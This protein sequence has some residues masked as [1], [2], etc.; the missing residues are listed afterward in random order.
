[1]NMNMFVSVFAF[2][3][4]FFQIVQTPLYV[5]S[6]GNIMSSFLQ[7]VCLFVEVC[8]FG[9]GSCLHQIHQQFCCFFYHDD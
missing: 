6:K 9:R 7:S 1:M 3:Y 2:S 4:L 5:K 8:G